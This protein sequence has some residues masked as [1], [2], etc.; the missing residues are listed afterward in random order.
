MNTGIRKIF[1]KIE[2][3]HVNSANLSNFCTST[4]P[5]DDGIEFVNLDLGMDN[6]GYF[7]TFTPE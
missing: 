5:E 1:T 2:F 4:L 7:I 6:L 3:S